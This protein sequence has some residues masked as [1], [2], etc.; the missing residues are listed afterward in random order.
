MIFIECFSVSFSF[1]SAEEHD[2]LVEHVLREPVDFA[3]HRRI[4]AQ[5]QTDHP[6]GH[7]SAQR[8]NGRFFSTGHAQRVNVDRHHVNILKLA[9]QLKTPPSTK[10][11]NKLH[12]VP[13]LARSR[14][15]F[16]SLNVVEWCFANFPLRK[17][18]WVFL[19]SFCNI[20]GI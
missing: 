8:R 1:C 7:S 15:T 2:K 16:F 20:E 18:V 6:A 5:L 19:F 12:C 3:Q 4:R 9:K 17:V 11:L 13:S 14:N 10:R